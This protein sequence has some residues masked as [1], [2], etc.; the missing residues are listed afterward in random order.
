MNK[1]QYKLNNTMKVTVYTM[2]DSKYEAKYFKAVTAYVF[3]FR[4]FSAGLY[5]NQ[6][7][8]NNE[9]IRED[10]ISTMGTRLIKLINMQPPST[11][12]RTVYRMFGGFE[13]GLGLG[14]SS[15]VKEKIKQDNEKVKKIV[16]PQ[17]E[18]GTYVEKA[19]LS[20]SLKPLDLTSTTWATLKITVEPGIKS[21][22]IFDYIKNA[23]LQLDERKRREDLRLVEIE[24]EI[25]FAPGATITDIKPLSNDEKHPDITRWAGVMRAL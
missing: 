20:T 22:D 24:N 25:L 6:M 23:H 15:D 9:P 19:F 10:G 17:F 2:S 5:I 11:E 16:T 4:N 14:K 7:Y 13:P 18:G 3:P 21:L 1:R 12:K 8:R